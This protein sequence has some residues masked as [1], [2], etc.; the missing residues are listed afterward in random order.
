MKK[1][2]KVLLIIVASVT[3]LLAGIYLFLRFMPEKSVSKQE[4]NFTLNATD[5]ANEYNLNPEGSDKKFIDR[6]IQVTGVISEISTDQNNS[7]VFVLQDK[8]SS[9][10]VLCTLDEKN[11]K[12]A[13]NY[14]IGSTVTIKGTCS[15]ML[16]EVVLHKCIIVKK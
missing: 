2:F 9:T 15:G 3:I 14:K 12:K 8:N 11:A 13:S 16:F 1:F 6:I 4:A 10:G 5:L 7:I